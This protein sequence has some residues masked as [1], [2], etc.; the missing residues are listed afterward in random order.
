MSDL[1]T[2][3]ELTYEHYPTGIDNGMAGGSTSV[4]TGLKRWSDIAGKAG[5]K[6]LRG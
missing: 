2:S 4:N 1:F 3:K 5:N 6:T